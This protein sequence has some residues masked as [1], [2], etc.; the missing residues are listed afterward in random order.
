MTNTPSIDDVRLNWL[1]TLR[2]QRRVSPRTLEAYGHA[3]GYYIGYLRTHLGAEL[4]LN[5][6]GDITHT[7]L[8]GW[9][10]HLKSKD[11]PLSARSMA[12]H[13]SA[14][15]SFH[16]HLDLH[17]GVANAAVSLMRGPRLKPTLPR[18]LNED[19]AIGLV[20][21]AAMDP[22]RREWEA[23]RD[24]AVYML[25]YGMGLR[26]SEALSLKASDVPLGESLRIVGKGNKMRTLP[27]LSEVR[28]AVEDYRKALPHLIE[29]GDKLFRATRGGEL[30]PRMVQ[31]QVQI[32][33]SRLGLSD[34]ATPHALRH[35]FATHLL[36]AGADLRSIQELLG[37]ASLSTTQKYTRVDTH[38][39]LSAYHAAH[40][41]G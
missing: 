22:D 32:L 25:L 41:K 30:S 38:A 33:R 39:L 23:K 28:E 12:Q 15:K 36:G 18:P 13:L 1:E 14:V 19:Q 2:H 10:A 17:F 11:L 26:I 5:D 21:E 34:R 16:T 4:T 3:F 27:V 6:M 40:P 20:N 37:H 7:D 9:M 31:A 24:I 8:R 35:S 29:P